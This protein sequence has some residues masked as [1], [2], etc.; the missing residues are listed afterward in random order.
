MS[1]IT[2]AHGHT[3]WHYRIECVA[4]TREARFFD[5][6]TKPGDIV[7]VQ[8]DDG[9]ALIPIHTPITGDDDGR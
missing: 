9:T 6:V 7:V 8:A 4:E 2:Q 3:L 5:A 1:S